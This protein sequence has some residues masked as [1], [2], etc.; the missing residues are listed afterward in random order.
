[1]AL[2]RRQYS[3]VN[4]LIIGAKGILAGPIHV[5]AEKVESAREYCKGLSPDDRNEN[6]FMTRF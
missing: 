3:S 6:D 5:M 4:Y 1:V 2:L